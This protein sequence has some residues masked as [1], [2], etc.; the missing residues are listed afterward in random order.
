M[1][2][3]QLAKVLSWTTAWG[4]DFA[5]VYYE[6]R[7]VN[8]LTVEDGRPDRSWSGLRSGV[9]IRLV[10]G[11]TTSYAHTNDLTDEGLREVARAAAH[12]AR[13]GTERPIDLRSRGTFGHQVK[14][15]PA[16]VALAEKAERLLD[17]DEA[18]RKV[19]GRV[20]Q[21]L[22]NYRDVG[23]R[24]IIANTEGLLVEDHRSYVLMTI[25]V[26]AA[27]NGRFQMGFRSMGET[28]GFEAFERHSPKDL[29]RKAARQAIT[30]LEARPAPSGA[31]TVV[32]TSGWGGVLFHEAC[33]HGLEA[34]A[35]ERNSSVFAGRLGREVASPLVTLIDDGSLEGGW[36]SLGVDDEGN[37]TQKTV[38][39]ERG[40][41]KSYMYDRETARR[42]GRRSTGNGRR[43]S[44]SNIPIPRMT[45]TYIAPGEAT[46]DD[47]IAETGRGLFV[48]DLRGG[49]V[50]TAT[51]D[52]V[53]TVSEG[54]LIEGGRLTDA[55]QGATLIGNGLETLRNIDMVADDLWLAPGSCGKDSQSV[56]AAC[57]QPTLRVRQLTVGGTGGERE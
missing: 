6:D 4:A 5:E 19:D 18:A 47:V 46:P 32:I 44:Y 39:I 53:F 37:P 57:G 1:E 26:I 11:D 56:A 2:A 28:C 17:A 29:G 24:I 21:V 8:A 22:L 51:G 10:R 27:Q 43:E 25:S 50:N 13:A 9:G 36:G 52:F 20:R 41:L 40:V 33:G 15:P 48:K 55:V 3:D 34:D 54:Y 31:M 12:G 30:N 7:T 49:Q 35:I 42:A 14:R 23:H 38:L 16:G 45:N